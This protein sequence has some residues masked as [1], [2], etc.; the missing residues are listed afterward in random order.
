MMNEWTEYKP[1]RYDDDDDLIV[2]IVIELLDHK[3][4][5]KKKRKKTD[6]IHSTKKRRCT[7]SL[8]FIRLLY[9]PYLPNLIL[10]MSANVCVRKFRK[11]I[12]KNSHLIW[13][14][15]QCMVFVYCRFCVSIF[16]SICLWSDFFFCFFWISRF[17]SFL[18]ISS[19]STINDRWSNQ[20]HSKKNHWI[21]EK[22]E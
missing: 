7:V 3:K 11:K 8:W 14:R 5:E 4:A 15:W 19:S 20:N 18:S 21:S 2:K 6:R 13:C 16:F 12:Y 9:Q 10:L 22:K 17:F 1:N